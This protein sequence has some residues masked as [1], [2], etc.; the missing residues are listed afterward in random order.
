[1]RALK[2]EQIPLEQIAPYER[3]ARLH[4]PEQ[5]TLL[6]SSINQFGFVNPCL[7]DANNVIIAGHN[8]AEVARQMGLKTI[9]AIRLSHLSEA[10]VK[11][12]RLADNS[13]PERSVWSPELVETE[14]AALEQMNFDVESLGLSDI[15]LPEMEEIEDAPKRTRSKQT[16]FVSIANQDVERAR[17]TIVTALNKAK[18]AHNL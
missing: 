6:K 1:M 7:I 18:I 16:I 12:L 5:Q 9:P 10:E 17:Q 2:I 15:Q 13:I 8:R 4:P 3:N 14:L 11:A